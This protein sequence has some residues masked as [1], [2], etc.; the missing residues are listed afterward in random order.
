MK[1]WFRFL[2]KNGLHKIR[3]FG[4]YYR[5]R[6]FIQKELCTAGVCFILNRC[7]TGGFS[8]SKS[9]L[10]RVL[11]PCYSKRKR[12]LFTKKNICKNCNQPVDL[13]RLKKNSWWICCVFPYSIGIDLV[14]VTCRSL[15]N[16]SSEL[17]AIWIPPLK[18]SPCAVR[19]AS[20]LLTLGGISWVKRW[21]KSR[22]GSRK[23]GDWW[24]SGN[25]APLISSPK[26][27]GMTKASESETLHIRSGVWTW[28]MGKI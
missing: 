18:Y 25:A 20:V 7:F 13:D 27:V 28:L 5:H 9:D 4:N 19:M 3:G 24:F 1:R 2:P 8:N 11:H 26:I 23:D 16:T 22:T 10:Q 12:V 17:L 15:Q 6:Q 14:E 21:W